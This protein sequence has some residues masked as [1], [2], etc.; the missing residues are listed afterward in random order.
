VKNIGGHETMQRIIPSVHVFHFTKCHL[1]I[2][3]HLNVAANQKYRL[4]LFDEDICI[5]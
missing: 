5:I 4:R 3:L 2:D 1:F